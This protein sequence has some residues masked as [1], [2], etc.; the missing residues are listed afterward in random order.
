MCSSDRGNR[1][2]LIAFC[3]WEVTADWWDWAVVL[4]SCSCAVAGPWFV[5]SAKLFSHLWFPVCWLL[6]WIHPFL[7]LLTKAESGN[8]V[9]A[10]LEELS[11]L[12]QRLDWRDKRLGG[13]NKCQ[14]L[15]WPWL[16]CLNDFLYQTCLLCLI[17]V[18]CSS[19]ASDFCHSGYTDA[20]SPLVSWIVTALCKC[21]L[22]QQHYK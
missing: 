11:N 14:V 9:P 19:P 21:S 8:C 22:K 16:L 12:L 17:L 15:A 4:C 10:V 5:W 7:S 3:S 20:E 2:S 18:S 13:S 1:D 6:L